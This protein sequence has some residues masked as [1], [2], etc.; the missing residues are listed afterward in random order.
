VNS[1]STFVEKDAL[2]K[3]KLEQGPPTFNRWTVALPAFTAAC[4]YHMVNGHCPYC[5]Y[6]LTEI[7]GDLL[8]GG[9][10]A[11]TTLQLAAPNRKYDSKERY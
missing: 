7:S 3:L 5:G 4:I 10:E 1:W 6:A 11:I 8:D 2:L 9:G